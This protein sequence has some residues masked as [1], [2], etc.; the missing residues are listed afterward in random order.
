MP[1]PL[2]PRG[3]DFVD[4]LAN[5]GQRRLHLLLDLIAE[6]LF[7]LAKRGLAAV[8]LRFA[9][10]LVGPV[11]RLGDKLGR[12]FTNLLEVVLGSLADIFEVEGY[13][14]RVGLPVTGTVGF[15]DRGHG[16]LTVG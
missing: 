7:D 8:L 14:V 9:P 1:Q 5:G 15:D 11:I 6:H 2:L 16:L 4:R 12:T 13:A 3:L 10:N